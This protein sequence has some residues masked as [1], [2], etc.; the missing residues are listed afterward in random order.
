MNSDLAVSFNG[1]GC[2]PTDISNRALG[3][4]VLVNPEWAPVM[5]GQAVDSEP[6]TIH[7]TVTGSHGDTG[8]DPPRHHGSR[9]QL[10][11]R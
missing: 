10:Q 11:V 3:Q 2:Y 7:A 9:A 6:V 4:I 8:G 1:G 5:H